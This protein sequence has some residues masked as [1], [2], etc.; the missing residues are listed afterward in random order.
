MWN[1]TFSVIFKHRVARSLSVFSQ[2]FQLQKKGR[3]EEE[4]KTQCPEDVELKVFESFSLMIYFKETIENLKLCP[5]IQ[6]SKKIKIV[7]LNF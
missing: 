7:D 6:F 3:E 2:G 5:K 1:D 4:V